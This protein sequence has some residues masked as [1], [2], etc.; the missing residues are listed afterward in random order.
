ASGVLGGIWPW[1]AAANG[2]WGILTVDVGFLL[3]GPMLLWTAARLNPDALAPAL[4]GDGAAAD[5]PP[6]LATS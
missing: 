1:T 5:A 6:R 2:W 4:A 3:M